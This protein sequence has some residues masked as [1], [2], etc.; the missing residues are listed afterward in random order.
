MTQV[1]SSYEELMQAV[2]DRR[3]DT[4]SLEIDMGGAYSKEYEDAKKEL[5]QAKAISTLAGQSEFLSDNVSHL[6]QKVASTKPQSRSIFIKFKRLPISEWASLMKQPTLTPLDQYE[7]ILPSTFIG[8]FGEDSASAEPLTTDYKVVSTTGDEC[9][10]PGGAL[11][12]VIQEFMSWQGS[13]GD[14]VIHPMKSG[15]D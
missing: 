11:S 1:F 8:V 14:V 9:I 3:Q 7:R 13:G 2:E 15:L 5:A 10:L 12:Q 4:L 6:E